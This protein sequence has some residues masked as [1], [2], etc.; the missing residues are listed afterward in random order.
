MIVVEF[1]SL[2]LAKA[3]YADPAYVEARRFALR[4]S[5]R[6]LVIFGGELG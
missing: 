5:N 1:P 6:I 2:E 3:C 4:A